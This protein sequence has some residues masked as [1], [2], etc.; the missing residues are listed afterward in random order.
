MSKFE[1]AALCGML[2]CLVV[3]SVS[4]FVM[5]GSYKSRIAA[6]T[7]TIDGLT[8]ELGKARAEREL[9]RKELEIVRKN[10]EDADEKVQA[11]HSGDAVANAAGILHK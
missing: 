11:L 2:L 3:M 10:R 8:A 5:V 4:F 9:L 6:Q 1:V 7:R